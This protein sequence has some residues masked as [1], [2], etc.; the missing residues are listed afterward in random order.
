M[1]RDKSVTWHRVDP[2]SLDVKG[3]TVAVVGGT[4]G[5]GRAISRLLAARGANVTVVG[6]TFRDAGVPGIE[7]I[8]APD[9]GGADAG[10]G[11]LMDRPF[12]PSTAGCVCP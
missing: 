11:T 1:K 7:F 5:L 12:L 3:W 9:R 4:G 2:S 8:S 6:Q 10:G